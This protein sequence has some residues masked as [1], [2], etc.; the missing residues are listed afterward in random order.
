MCGGTPE[1]HD[2]GSMGNPAIQTARR[3]DRDSRKPAADV[4]RD[5][6]GVAYATNDRIFV[7]DVA[8]KSFRSLPNR[9]TYPTVAFAP[10][11][12]LAVASERGVALWSRGSDTPRRLECGSP[13]TALAFGPDGRLATGT[14]DGTVQ[15]W[16]VAT[17]TAQPSHKHGHEVGELAFSTRFLVSTGDNV[18]VRDL[19]SGT[20]VK[21][22]ERGAFGAVAIAPDETRV[23][24]AS[25]DGTVWLWDLDD[26]THAH[27]VLGKAHAPLAFSPDGTLLAATADDAILL[28]ADDLPRGESALRSWLK[29]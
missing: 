8:T 19:A 10:D 14:L 20:T 27:R 4:S 2:E 17:A 24:A 25:A 23:A 11:R 22:A 1:P 9:A 18:I 26:P 16:D 6:S 21:L 7:C 12:T 3:H 28:F 15:I 13:V 29:R 5:G